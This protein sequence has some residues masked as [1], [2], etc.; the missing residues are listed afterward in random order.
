MMP[1]SR[2]ML[3][4]TETTGLD[5]PHVIQLAHSKPFLWSE[6]ITA[7]D[8]T[9]RMFKPGKPISTGAKAA[10]HIIEADLTDHPSWSGS[11]YLDAEYLIGH[12][13][14]FDWQALGEQPLV[15]RI[16]TLALA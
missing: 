9:V 13:I 8:Y 15:K 2:A 16:C 3:V 11:Y 4:D 10:H 6:E 5:E 14:D 1:L 12:N 7:G